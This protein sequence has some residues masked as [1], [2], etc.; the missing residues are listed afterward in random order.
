MREQLCKSTGRLGRQALKDVLEVA[1]RVVAVELG[2]L[3]AAH[4][5]CTTLT[6][7]AGRWI[8]EIRLQRT[9]S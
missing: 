4:D 6:G 1:V 3:Y 9:S 8:G 2:G 5:H 7:A